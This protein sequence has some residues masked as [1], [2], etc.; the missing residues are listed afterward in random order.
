MTTF[1]EMRCL[2]DNWYEDNYTKE[3]WGIA[4]NPATIDRA[5]K[6]LTELSARIPNMRPPNTNADPNDGSVSI[7]WYGPHGNDAFLIFCEEPE[8]DYIL[9]VWGPQFCLTKEINTPTTDDMVDAYYWMLKE[10]EDAA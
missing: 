10:K 8:E 4:P 5:E 9:K 7:D 3:F 2:K 1:P 6:A